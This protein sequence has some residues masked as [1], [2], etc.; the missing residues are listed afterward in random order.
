MNLNGFK[1]SAVVLLTFFYSFCAVGLGVNVHYCHG[2]IASVSI[3]FSKDD[4][5]CQKESKR[6]CCSDKAVVLKIE[7]K[8]LKAS[9]FTWIDNSV[10]ILQQVNPIAFDRCIIYSYANASLAI[11]ADYP[12]PYPLYIAHRKFRI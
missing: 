12:P 7:S 6:K 5:C 2:K 11:G 3:G 1:T 4:C 8:Q 10:Y 9:S